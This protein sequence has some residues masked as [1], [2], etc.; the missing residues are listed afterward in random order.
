M[1]NVT[2]HRE[3]QF[4]RVQT[5][6]AEKFDDVSMVQLG[7]NLNFPIKIVQELLVVYRFVLD[8]LDCDQRH[9]VA[10]LRLILAF[11]YFTKEAFADLLAQLDALVRQLELFDGR[12][13]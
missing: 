12:V 13:Q 5:H 9:L 8:H 6:D 3:H 4:V 2:H 11:V 1:M 7:E 10:V